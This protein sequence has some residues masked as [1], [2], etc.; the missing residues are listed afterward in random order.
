MAQ[1]CRA[2]P[3]ELRP[4]NRRYWLDLPMRSAWLDVIFPTESPL[5]WYA[6]G[7]RLDGRSNAD[8]ANDIDYR[9]DGDADP[10]DGLLTPEQITKLERWLETGAYSCHPETPEQTLCASP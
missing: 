7:R 8:R 4:G 1:S 5:L 9:T 3:G 10:H 2:S 6:S